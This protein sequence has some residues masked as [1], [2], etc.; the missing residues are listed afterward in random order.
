MVPALPQPITPGPHLPI[1]TLPTLGQAPH[2]RRQS[3]HL[4]LIT[5]TLPPQE[6]T[7]QELTLPSR[8]SETAGRRL[9]RHP[10]ES[11]H[12]LYLHRIQDAPFVLSDAKYTSQKSLVK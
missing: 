4:T 9:L 11:H 5:E 2:S 6:E 1:L 7:H 12:H 10:N 3:H 8:R